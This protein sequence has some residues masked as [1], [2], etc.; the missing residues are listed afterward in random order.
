MAVATGGGCCARAF[1]LKDYAQRAS[2]NN[3]LF[4]LFLYFLGGLTVPMKRTHSPYEAM[5]GADSPYGVGSHVQVYSF[6]T[7]DRPDRHVS[8][9][10]SLNSISPREM[11]FAL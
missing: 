2:P 7:L 3:L 5:S 9:P 6:D 4:Y 10:F 1:V 8:S 11:V